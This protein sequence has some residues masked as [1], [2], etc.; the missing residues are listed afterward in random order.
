[1]AKEKWSEQEK[2]IAHRAYRAAYLRECAAVSENVR[3]MSEKCNDPTSVWEIQDY[4]WKKRK[5]VDEKYDFR[6][7][8]LISVFARLMHDGWLTND[9]LAGIDEDKV[10]EICRVAEF[11]KSL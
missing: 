11:Y 6:Y 1:M 4:L 2:E 10:Q 5:E 9:D 7:Y 8:V 3:E